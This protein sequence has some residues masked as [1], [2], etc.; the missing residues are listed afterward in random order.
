MSRDDLDMKVDT[1]VK[2]VWEAIHPSDPTQV[3]VEVPHGLDCNT[4]LSSIMDWCIQNGINTYV[5][6]SWPEYD[7]EHDTFHDVS[8]WALI[9]PEQRTAF[10]LRWPST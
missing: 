5:I 9:E 6:A 4:Y 10:K 3:R 2:R 8:M 1:A 7:D